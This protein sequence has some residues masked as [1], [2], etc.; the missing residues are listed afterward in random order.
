MLHF[1]IPEMHAYMAE[2]FP[3]LGTRFEVLTLEPMRLTARMRTTAA[4][5]RPGGS[6]SGPA[7]FALADCAFY[8]ATLAMI[9][10]EPLTVT[11]SCAIDFMRKPGPG[12]LT[13]DARILKLGRSLAVGDVLVFSEAVDGPVARAGLT[14]SI[15][16]GRSSAAGSSAV[17]NRSRS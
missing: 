17:Q 13:A 8:M 15:P 14:Y 5:L 1:T 2:V 10:R 3:E 6:V 4:D 11:T 16:P 7:I 9:G 12:F